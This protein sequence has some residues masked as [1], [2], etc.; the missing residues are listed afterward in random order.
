MFKKTKKIFFCEFIRVFKNYKIFFFLKKKK[1]KKKKKLLKK[2]SKNNNF[3]FFFFWKIGWGVRSNPW[4][5]G[6]GQGN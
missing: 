5:N 6:H 1:K 2:N 3:F 4:S